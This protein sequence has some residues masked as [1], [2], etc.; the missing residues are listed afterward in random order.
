MDITKWSKNVRSEGDGSTAPRS[1]GRDTELSAEVAQLRQQVAL[2]HR[3]CS[4]SSP[5]LLSDLDAEAGELPHHGG[6]L[7]VLDAERGLVVGVRDE[8]DH[9]VDRGEGGERRGVARSARACR[10][11]QWKN[12]RGQDERLIWRRQVWQRQ[13]PATRVPS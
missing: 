12:P 6:E 2:L 8:I 11:R 4:P 1:I 7:L 13:N 3:W 9:A 5:P 10:T